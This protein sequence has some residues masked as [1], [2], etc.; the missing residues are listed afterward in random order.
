MSNENA[1]EI[2]GTYKRMM[3]D[4]QQI[5]TKIS[6]VNIEGAYSVLYSTVYSLMLMHGTAYVGERRA[7]VSH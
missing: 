3:A 4:C 6:E 2:L 1:E 7:Q 5:A